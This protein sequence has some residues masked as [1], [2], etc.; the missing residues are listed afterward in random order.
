MCSKQ[1]ENLNLSM[2]NM[3]TKVNQPK[4]SRKHISCECQCRFDGRKCNSDEWWENDKC[5]CE[6]KKR[7]VCKKIIFGILLH[8]V[9][10]MEN[11]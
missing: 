6:F 8:E 2:F 9:F 10:R 11:I 3:I 4:A 7:H 5:Q 1:I